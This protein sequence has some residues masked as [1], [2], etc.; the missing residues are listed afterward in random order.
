MQN[1]EGLLG[2]SMIYI[3][4]KPIPVASTR[5]IIDGVRNMP[6]LNHILVLH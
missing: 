2:H 6:A 3:Q 5:W 1:V 4:M